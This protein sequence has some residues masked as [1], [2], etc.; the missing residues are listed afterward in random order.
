MKRGHRYIVFTMAIFSLIL[1]ACT[2]K[3]VKPDLAFAGE[4]HLKNIRMLTNGGENAE[5]Y[6]SFDESQL[7]YQ[8]KHDSIKCDQIFIMNLDGSDKRMVSTGKGRTTCSYFLPGDQQIIYAST[9][10]VDE[11]CPPPPDFSRGYVWKVYSSY[12]LYIANA[13]GS[14]P[15]PFLP[16]PG[17]DAEATVSPRGDK[18]VFTSQRNGDLDIYTVNIDGSGLKQLT[19][20]IGYDGGAF[21]SWDGSKIV[22][23]AYHPRTEEELKRYR[24]LLAEELIEPNNFQLFVMDADGSNKRQ[25]THND[26]AN[27]APFFHP[28]NKRIIFCS[29]M[30]TTESTQRDFN[31]WMINEDGTGLKQITFFKGFDGFPMF[32]HDGKKLVFASNRFNKKKGETNV[33]IADWVE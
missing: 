8:S 24:K 18:I 25:I 4:K 20:E 29:N 26:F 11:N 13:D 2:K 33:F 16:S 31:L 22:Y 15:Q 17:Y 5:A 3:E 19:H 32:T 27:F 30:G 23:R 7:I 14:D 12:D 10:G 21:F 9:H 1:I 6:F 28:D